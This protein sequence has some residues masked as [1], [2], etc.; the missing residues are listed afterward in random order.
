MVESL[1]LT[2]V[3]L[4]WSTEIKRCIC[5]CD[6]SNCLIA[7]PRLSGFRANKVTLHPSFESS[8]ALASPIPLLPPQTR[9]YLFLREIFIFKI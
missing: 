2:S 9:A 8:M 5:P 1:L 7:S 3:G 6:L 4:D